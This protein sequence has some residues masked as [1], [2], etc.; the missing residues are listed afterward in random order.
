MEFEFVRE[1]MKQSA[2]ALAEYNRNVLW[3]DMW[4]R[5]GLSKRDRSLITLA[6]VISVGRPGPIEFH[7][8]FGLHNGL[9]KEEI[10]EVITH[11]AFYAG[12]P[13]GSNASIIAAD[14]LGEE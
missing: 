11:M 3:D 10:S 14:V 1:E 4:E 6:Y 2:P 5:P 7:I 8:R 13:A 9:T 12:F